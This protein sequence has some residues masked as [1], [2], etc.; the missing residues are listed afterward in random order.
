MEKADNC[1]AHFLQSLWWKG[2]SKQVDIPIETHGTYGERRV[3]C[4]VP[5]SRLYQAEDLVDHIVNLHNQSL[6]K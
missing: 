5:F 6:S 3:V 1:T 2:P 4:R